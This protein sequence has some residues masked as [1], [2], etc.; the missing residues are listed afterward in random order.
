M[1]DTVGRDL[2][3]ARVGNA[4]ADMFS[5]DRVALD[6]IPHAARVATLRVLPVG[7]L[8]G[9]GPELNRRAVAQEAI[10]RDRVLLAVLDR[11]PNSIPRKVI[12]DDA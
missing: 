11:D 2:G 7:R 5:G 12:V 4:N 8:D 6:A 9:I 3:L 1:T 10:V